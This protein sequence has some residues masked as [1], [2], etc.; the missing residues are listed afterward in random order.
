MARSPKS[1]TLKI[2]I[3][4]S[5]T[6]S[7]L[8]LLK[9]DNRTPLFRYYRYRWVLYRRIFFYFLMFVNDIP[10]HLPRPKVTI[11]SI[12]IITNFFSVLLEVKKEKKKITFMILRSAK[13]AV[14]KLDF[15]LG[16]DGFYLKISKII[17]FNPHLTH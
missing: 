14:D 10:C 15:L 7:Q 11:I 2:S 12:S 3:V 9:Y 4:L 5:W 1:E 6:F 8:S 13:D 16:F 17:D